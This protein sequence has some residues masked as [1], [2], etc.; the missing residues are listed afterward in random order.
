MLNK[1]LGYSLRKG[2]I[3]LKG[4]VNPVTAVTHLRQ[5]VFRDINAGHVVVYEMKRS[6]EF[7]DKD[8]FAF[9][10][11]PNHFH[12]LFSLTND[13][14][15]LSV[16]GAVKS[17]SAKRLNEMYRRGQQQVWQRGFHD[18]ALRRDEDV[19]RVAGYIVSSTLRAGLF[20]RIG[21]YP[22]W[23]AVWL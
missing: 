15:L 14:V 10:V 22:L 5:P 16:V 20:K 12:W 6:A 7:G 4:H 1:Y 8:T 19:A 11:M 23:D 21:D 13:R 3:S 17:Y 9:V 18:H 2:R